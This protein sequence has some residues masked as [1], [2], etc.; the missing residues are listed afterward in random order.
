MSGRNLEDPAVLRGA[1][2]NPLFYFTLT[3]LLI[4]FLDEL[5]FGIREAA[6]P[7]IRDDLRLSYVE[8]GALLSVPTVFGNLVE[9]L[10]GILGDVWKRR[11][12]V[13]GG[14]AFFAAAALLVSASYSFP[15]LMLAFVA[16]N[17]ASGAFV[18]LS[19]AALMDAAPERHEQNMARWTL[20]GSVG[21][22]VGPL[23][24]G[25]SV[26]L[27]LGWRWMFVGL[28]VF[29]LLMLAA[30]SRF[31]FRTPASV[32]E[33]SVG[34]G[35]KEGVRRALAA[36]RRREVLRWLVLLE[37]GDFTADILNGYLAL[38]F[39]DVMRVS[40]SQAA[41]AV[42]V[43][44]CVGLPGDF[45]LLPLLERVRGLRYLRWSALA[46]LFIFP[47]FLL[48]PTVPSK[49]A[50]LGLLG[51][52]NTGWYSILKAQLYTSMPGQSGTV[53]AL[54]N[55]FGLV[56]G[57]MPLALGLVAQRYGL[58]TMMWLLLIGPAA[59]L[60]G[61]RK[62]RGETGKGVKGEMGKQQEA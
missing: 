23:V 22:A 50:L 37:F 62:E 19:Q 14:G 36:L 48:A 45:L 5:L 10:V 15:V 52:A 34:V 61:L 26:G 25:A 59:L 11:A 58:S 21:N 17:P 43:W 9:P 8:I 54:Q 40:E 32:A 27:G 49:L 51:F 53:M 4:E 24:V 57:L 18:N 33:R 38:Y 55:V 16:F 56:S 41:L 13:L 2:R 29:S 7:S 28:F 6:W 42:V 60:I 3:L 35:L 1:R 39:V 20:F 44:T 31:S 46:V 12:L 47:S 30:A